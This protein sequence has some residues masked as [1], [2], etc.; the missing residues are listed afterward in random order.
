MRAIQVKIGEFVGKRL[1]VELHHIGVSAFVVG[2][3]VLALGIDRIGAPSVKPAFL[4]AVGGDIL[5]A[6]HAETLLR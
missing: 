1:F 6:I 5:M 3:A 4:R 2:M